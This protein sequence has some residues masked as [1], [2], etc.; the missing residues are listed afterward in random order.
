MRRVQ[1]GES[2]SLIARFE[3]RVTLGLERKTQ[4]HTK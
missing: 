2:L 3:H 1:G 4:H